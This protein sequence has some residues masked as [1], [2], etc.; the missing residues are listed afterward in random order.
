MS[1]GPVAARSE[2]DA[3]ADQR[4]G[5]RGGNVLRCEK[6]QEE[7]QHRRWLAGDVGARR[8]RGWRAREPGG[9]GKGAEEVHIIKSW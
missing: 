9:G 6:V 3:P 4:A 5:T 2:A 7:W 8:V 1:G